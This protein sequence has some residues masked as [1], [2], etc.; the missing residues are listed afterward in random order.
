MLLSLTTT[1]QPATD[2]GF[3]LYKHPD[4]QQA[5]SLP[6]GTAH[7]FYPEATPRRCTAALLLDVDPI[8]LVRGRRGAGGEAGLL[9]Q[10]VNDRPYAVSSFLSVGMRHVFASALGGRS[11]HRPEL[12]ELAIPLEAR[13][14]PLRCR[15]GIEVAR[16]LFEPLGYTLTAA[17]VGGG[18]YWDVTIS[19]VSTLARMLTHLYV[20]LPVLDDQKHYWVGD[21]EV[22]KLLR[23]G[24][25]WLAQHPARNLIAQRYLKHQ[26]RLTRLAL[27][28]IEAMD[29][30]IPEDDEPDVEPTPPR[31][32]L[33]D[34]RLQRVAAEIKASGARSVLD[35]GCGSGKLLDLLLRDP[36][37]ERIVGL[38]ISSRELARAAQ[39]LHLEERTEAQRDRISLLHG[40]L[41][42]RDRRLEGFD[43]A[44]IVEVIE[45]IDPPR[46]DAFGDV[47][48]GTARPRTIVLT[49]PNADYNARYPAL[50]PGEMRH[51]D[52]RFEWSR[53]A[54]RRWAEDVAGRFG[55]HVRFDGVGEM[56]IDL[57]APTQMG[58]FTCN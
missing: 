22:E 28:Q 7:V 38:D 39:R 3:L 26:K 30:S 18:T 10:Y 27:Q 40:A 5:F 41:T 21:D 52:H 36:H 12:A 54:F 24:E 46:L 48:F 33:N 16:M 29:D 58:V 23:H 50:G 2:L 14:V 1:H 13:V 56:D 4:K 53:A 34:E 35:L 15:G 55:Y 8:A 6:F 19:G 51:I 25:D 57:G 37:Y 47:V 31:R 17:P 49:T 11:E 44:A 20:L 32:R 45:H 43:A 9:D 42:Y